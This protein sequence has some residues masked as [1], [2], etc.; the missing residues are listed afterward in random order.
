[1]LE[2][3]TMSELLRVFSV[4]TLV[5]FASD[6]IVASTNTQTELKFRKDFEQKKVKLNSKIARPSAH[7]HSNPTIMDELET[8]MI[9]IN[10]SPQEVT[11][12]EESLRSSADHEDE[13][14]D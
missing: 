12:I 8:E 2:N 6:S 3:Q 5:F 7:P 9:R 13:K 11:E 10:Q 4:L 1:M 14:L